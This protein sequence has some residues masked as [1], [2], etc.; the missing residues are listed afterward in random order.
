MNQATQVQVVCAAL[1]ADQSELKNFATGDQ[2]ESAGAG[3]TF[4]GIVRDNDDGRAVVALEYVAHPSAAV[5]LNLIARAV[6]TRHPEVS[7]LRVAHGTGM[8]QIGDYALVAEVSC[9][10][11]AA[12]FGA[13]AELVEQVKAE[14]PIWKRQIFADGAD[15]WVNS[16]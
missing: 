12:A 11:R 16:P 14:L 9:A 13:C 6:A 15:E 1:V 8:L 10:H 4:V 5:A 2:P 7:R 3:V